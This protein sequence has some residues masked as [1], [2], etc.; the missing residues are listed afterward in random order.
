M[1]WSIFQKKRKAA[2]Q[3]RFY[4]KCG[5]CNTTSQTNK[6]FVSKYHNDSWYIISYNEHLH[7]N[8]WTNIMAVALF[9]TIKYKNISISLKRGI[10][11][12]HRS[13]SLIV[14]SNLIVE[15]VF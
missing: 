4:D 9:A 1:D 15:I 14:Y 3:M 12:I 8:I 5:T 13:S 6:T 7:A 11:S 2:F 10:F